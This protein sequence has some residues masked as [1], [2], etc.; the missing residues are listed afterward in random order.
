MAIDRYFLDRNGAVTRRIQGKP[1]EGHVDIAKEV[2]PSRGIVPVDYA[3]HYVQMYRL[4]FVRVVEHN[5]GSVEVEHG[6]A[7]TAAQKRFVRALDAQGKQVRI[8][9]TTLMK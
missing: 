2:L 9:K 8:I 7:L 6:P 5:D 1:G 4:K 3:D